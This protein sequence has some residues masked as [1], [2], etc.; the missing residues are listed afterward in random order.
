MWDT[1]TTSL[2]KT[3]HIN[4]IIL[5]KNKDLLSIM[6]PLRLNEPI[7]WTILGYK[8]SHM[9]NSKITCHTWYTFFSK[10]H[11]KKLKLVVNKFFFGAKLHTNVE[12]KNEKGMFAH[13][14]FSFFL[15]FVEKFTKFRKLFSFWKN[16][17]HY[18]TWILDVPAFCFFGHV[19]ETY[20][21][22]M[23]NP[24]LGYSHTMMQH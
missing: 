8:Y 10:W 15:F 6:L 24:Y 2:M 4:M 1:L 9:H 20:C 14:F 18:S 23:H 12:N 13:I 7:T 16:F 19:V 17:H 22:L 3:L 21:H 5:D 11:V